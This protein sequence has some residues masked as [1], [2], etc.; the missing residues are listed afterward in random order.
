MIPH[1]AILTEE[2]MRGYCVIDSAVSENAGL[3]VI[4]TDPML[5]PR[6]PIAEQFSELDMYVGL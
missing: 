5:A 2:A 1:T 3:T 4:L 6:F